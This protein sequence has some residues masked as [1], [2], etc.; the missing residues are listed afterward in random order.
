M[1]AAGART[2]GFSNFDARAVV[3]VAAVTHK[4]ISEAVRI[5]REVQAAEIPLAVV[6]R[7][8]E[9]TPTFISNVSSSRELSSHQ[10]L[11]QAG[12]DTQDFTAVSSVTYVSSELQPEVLD[13]TVTALGSDAAPTVVVSNVPLN[14]EAFHQ[15]GTP[16]KFT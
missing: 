7:N 5:V 13:A 1:T 4:T 9:S 3:Q 16:S 12:L 14:L 6:L 8:G 11:K 15:A 2:S 10:Q